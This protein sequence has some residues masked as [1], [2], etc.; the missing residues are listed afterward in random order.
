MQRARGPETPTFAAVI[1][2]SAASA[3]AAAAAKLDVNIKNPFFSELRAK[4]ADA[5]SLDT[6]IGLVKSEFLRSFLHEVKYLQTST[7]LV[8]REF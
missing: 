8:W 5:A 7:C 4:A 1:G 3:S 2:A 6:L